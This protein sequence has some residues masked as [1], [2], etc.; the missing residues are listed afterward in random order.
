MSDSPREVCMQ[1]AEAALKT[2]V[3]VRPWGGSYRDDPTVER[4]YKLPQQI[5]K[6]PHI[7]LLQASGSRLS[8][9]P[10]DGATQDKYVDLFHVELV[11][12]VKRSEGISAGKAMED[13]NRDCKIT[14]A[15]HVFT[16]ALINLNDF[17]EEYV[18][19]YPDGTACFVLPFIAHL[20]DFLEG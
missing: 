5:N 8:N 7:C 9:D 13:C 12:Y 18:E 4:E 19:F 16:A 3:G 1:R 20:E 14:L 2:M 15:S 10:R 6:F 17:G 11:V